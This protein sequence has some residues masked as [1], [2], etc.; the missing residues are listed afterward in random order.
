M[1]A[2]QIKNSSN[3]TIKYHLTKEGAMATLRMLS[4]TKK[5][6]NSYEEVS[7]LYIPENGREYTYYIDND[8]TPSILDMF[9]TQPAEPQSPCY[10]SYINIED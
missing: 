7:E 8:T 5:V 4:H 1:K 9:S 6:Y 10:V 2:I 3:V